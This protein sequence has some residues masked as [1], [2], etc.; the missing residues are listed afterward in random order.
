MDTARSITHELEE[1]AR[2]VTQDADGFIEEEEDR[3]ERRIEWVARQIAAGAHGVQIVWLSGP[4][5]VGK[6]TTAARLRAALEVQGVQAFSVSLDDFYLGL[7][8]VPRFEDGKIDF[9]SP[10]A[11]DLPRL[12][13]CLEELTAAGETSLPHYDFE[14]GERSREETW[15]SARGDAVILFEGIHAFSPLMT[16]GT[17]AATT[18]RRVFVNTRSRF[19]S[20]QDILLCRRDIRLSRRL[21]RDERTRGSSFENTMS[22]WQG[23]LRGDEEH[24]LPF[25]TDADL[26]VDTTL[27]YEPCVLA[28]LLTPALSS[29]H[30]TVFDKEARRLQEVY[31]RFVPLSKDAVPKGSVL[32]EFIG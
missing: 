4:S 21:L 28:P 1:I 24:V 27:G 32:R 11:L 12:H 25:V 15:L 20:A 26:T 5:S 7:S 18:S 19:M 9:E 2:R 30:G 16:Q 22:M 10:Y 3:Y 8:K 23:V 29:L 31:M 6:T 13:R 17:S 14:A